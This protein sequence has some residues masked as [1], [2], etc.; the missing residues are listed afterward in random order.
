MVCSRGESNSISIKGRIC[1]NGLKDETLCSQPGWVGRAGGV[2]WA[3]EQ[4]SEIKESG[5]SPRA[6]GELES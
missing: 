4:A 3:E 5:D 1:L 6:E 2:R